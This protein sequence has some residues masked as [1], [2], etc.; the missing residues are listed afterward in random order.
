[1]QAVLLRKFA[2]FP[3]YN[4]PMAKHNTVNLDKELAN[5]VLE[6]YPKVKNPPLGYPA[7]LGMPGNTWYERAKNYETMYGKKV[8]KMEDSDDSI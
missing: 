4:K 1:M 6:D 3:L 5:Q 8:E 7:L 2:H